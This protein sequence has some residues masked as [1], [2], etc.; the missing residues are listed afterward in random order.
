MPRQTHTRQKSDDSKLNFE[1][2]EV[3][4]NL[5]PENVTFATFSRP[6]IGCTTPR[7]CKTV[8]ESFLRFGG[9]IKRLPV[10]LTA[11]S[12]VVL[13]LSKVVPG[14]LG[15]VAI[16]VYPPSLDI[17]LQSFQIPTQEASM[18]EDAYKVA[19]SHSR[20]FVD[21][22]PKKGRRS[23]VPM[24]DP[25][26]LPSNSKTKTKKWYKYTQYRQ[27]WDIDIVYLPKG[28]DKNMFTVENL[29]AA[30]RFE[31]KLMNYPGFF[32]FCWK[33][34]MIRRDPILSTKYNAC[35][36]A[37]SVVDFFFPSHFFGITFYDGQGQNLTESSMKKTLRLLLSKPFTYWFVDRNFSAENPKTSFLRAQI[38]FG[39]PLKGYNKRGYN[40]G[41]PLQ[42]QDE[43][44]IEFMKGFVQFISK[45]SNE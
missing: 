36:P 32:D 14:I 27:K 13:V 3:E 6:K 24:P 23:A 12:I 19:R 35:A 38:K 8:R 4:S 21:H 44:F 10:N 30:H 42:E 11:L 9:R 5:S 22:S 15:A 33:W 41:I 25:W 26:A 40:K 31:Q 7:W 18:H 43:K 37:I 16:F 1:L 29:L 28:E 45:Q 17:S 2:V 34:S 20:R 39:F